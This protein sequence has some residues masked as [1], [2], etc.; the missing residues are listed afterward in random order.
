VN[1]QKEKPTK[2]KTPEKEGTQESDN[3][4]IKVEQSDTSS[5]EPKETNSV[6]TSEIEKKEEEKEKEK[7]SESSTA[8]KKE[9]CN[10]FLFIYNILIYYFELNRKK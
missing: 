2:E 9:V 5:T 6:A 7:E 1:L 10:N 4:V 3:V 8:D